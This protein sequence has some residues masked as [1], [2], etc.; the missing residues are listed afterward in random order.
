[1]NSF[2]QQLL[3]CYKKRFFFYLDNQTNLSDSN[4][5]IIKRYF[6]RQIST[7][8]IRNIYNLRQKTFFLLLI[9]ATNFDKHIF[10][11]VN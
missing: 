3:N 2:D 4:K 8:N 1:M 7:K 10:S 6:L 9:R 11:D 5:S